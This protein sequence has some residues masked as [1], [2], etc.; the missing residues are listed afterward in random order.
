MEYDEL[1]L[2]QTLKLDVHTQALAQQ[3]W[4]WEFWRD[5]V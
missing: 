5:K 3:L 1:F 4:K 2:I